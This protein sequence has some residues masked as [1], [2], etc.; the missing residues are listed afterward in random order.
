[1]F[2]R[3]LRVWLSTRR[4]AKRKR[5][6]MQAYFDG[7]AYGAAKLLHNGPGAIGIL[8]D[9]S[10]HPSE[11]LHPFDSGIHKAIADYKK[12]VSC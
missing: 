3:N 5:R 6:Q 1:M 8:E 9:E 10:Y 7:Y 11:P 4:A 2:F 12:V